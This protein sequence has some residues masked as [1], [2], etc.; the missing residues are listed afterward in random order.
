M[1]NAV[2]LV[3]LLGTFSF[4][5]ECKSFQS[6]QDC[7]RLIECFWN[8]RQGICSGLAEFS[9]KQPEVAS[10]CKS[11]T[12]MDVCYSRVDC[13]WVPKLGHCEDLTNWEPNQGAAASL[14]CIEINDENACWSY[15][16]CFWNRRANQ[17]NPI[18]PA[19]STTTSSASI[20][21]TS[22]TATEVYASSHTQANFHPSSVHSSGEPQMQ[23]PK[24]CLGYGDEASCWKD[25]KCIWDKRLNVCL[26]LTPVSLNPFE[27]GI[28]KIEELVMNAVS[29]TS[30]PAGSSS[31]TGAGHGDPMHFCETFDMDTCRADDDCV[32]DEATLQCYGI[33]D[34]DCARLPSQSMCSENEDCLWSPEGRCQSLCARAFG[35]SQCAFD[36]DCIW[37]GATSSCLSIFSSCFEFLSPN[38]CVMNEVCSWNRDANSCISKFGPCTQH[39]DEAHCTLAAQFNTHCEWGENP[40]QEEVF[41]C[42]DPF[43]TEPPIIECQALTDKELCLE[44]TDTQSNMP[45]VWDVP[46]NECS[47]YVFDCEDYQTQATCEGASF[48]EMRCAWDGE[49]DFSLLA[50]AGL[51]QAVHADEQRFAVPFILAAGFCGFISAFLIVRSRQ[52]FSSNLDQPLYETP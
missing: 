28:S 25:T 21:T 46:R 4:G 45:C 52:S 5:E 50:Q 11:F 39:S 36:E 41:G 51:L 33:N 7:T 29:S 17:C 42:Q 22:S 20:V 38:A 48:R 19:E 43:T 3:V 35:E 18:S 31:K 23:Q 44:S 15:P 12:S 10:S 8:S 13:F 37:E 34:S 30:Q 2:I 16:D 49:C 24:P 14:S 27:V 47:T 9:A 32:L 26:D 6:L 1:L 40:G